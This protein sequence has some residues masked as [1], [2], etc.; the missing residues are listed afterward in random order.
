MKALA[1]IFPRYSIFTVAPTSTNRKT[2]AATH[3]FPYFTESLLATA[4]L[5]FCNPIP[6]NITAINDENVI[7]VVSL[8]SITTSKNE[9]LKM[10]STFDVSRICTFLK[11]YASNMPR[12]NPIAIPKNM[13]TGIFTNFS[14]EAPSP[15][16]IPTNVENRTMTYTS[17]TDA[18]ARINCGIPSFTP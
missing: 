18:P 13:E 7:A 17:S 2:S 11:K 14:I 16:I 5:F 8:S 3:N 1:P 6:I 4:S 12:N 15:C 10:I 9:M